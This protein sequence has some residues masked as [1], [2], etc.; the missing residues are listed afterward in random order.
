MRQNRQ[1][2]VASKIASGIL[3]A[4][5]SSLNSFRTKAVPHAGAMELPLRRKAVCGL[6]VAAWSCCREA[7]ACRAL[8]GQQVTAEEQMRPV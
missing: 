2:K 1:L 4:P 5:T 3:F 6:L 7:V 8:F